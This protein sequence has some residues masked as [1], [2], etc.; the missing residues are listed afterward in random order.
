MPLLIIKMK[1]MIMIIVTIIIKNYSKRRKSIGF[2]LFVCLCLF[3]CVCVFLLL[4]LLLVFC[5]V[6]ACCFKTISSLRRELYAQVARAQ[7]C[8]NHVQHLSAY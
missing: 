7:A 3:V 4:F 2:C 8:A 1:I 5:F 6:F